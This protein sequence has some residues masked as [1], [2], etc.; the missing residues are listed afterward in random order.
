MQHIRITRL[1]LGPKDITTMT[2]AAEELT[3]FETF[4]SVEI[5]Y[6]DLTEQWILYV[7]RPK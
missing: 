3:S 1:K 4:R 7:V 5:K 2:P 6:H